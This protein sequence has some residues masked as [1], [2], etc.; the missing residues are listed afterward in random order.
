M[1]KLS[2]DLRL[3]EAVERLRDDRSLQVGDYERLLGGVERVLAVTLG[4]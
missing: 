3:G 1:A 4:G 2:G